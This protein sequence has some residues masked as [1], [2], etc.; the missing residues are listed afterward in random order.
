MDVLLERLQETLS[1]LELNW[2]V[3]FVDDGSRDGTLDRLRDLSL[4]RPEV[5]YVALTRNFGHEAATTAGLSH[6]RGD[7]V[8]LMDADLQD[9]PEVIPDMVRL[10]RQ[11]YHL[12]YA[13]RDAREGEG[14]LK[15]WTSRLF[16]RIMARITSF[17]L[18]ADV[19][20]FRL[21]SRPAVEALLRMPERNRFVRGMVAWSGFRS[22]AV[23]FRRAPRHSGV[24]KYSMWRLIVLAL[25]A[26]TSFSA[27]P[28]RLVSVAGLV[29]TGLSLLGAATVVVQKLFFG[30]PIPGYAFLVTGVFFL[31][32]VQILMLGVIGEYVGR[33]FVDTQRRPI[34]VVAER[35]GFEETWNEADG[36][37]ITPRGG[38]DV[39]RETESR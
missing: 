28:L 10:W 5:R 38:Y 19:G 32:G 35:G 33:I 20:D 17:D 21:M 29:V 8:V 11:G 9:P 26:M 7:A 1:A 23:T 34:Y 37:G 36:A 4:S 3:L 2:E 18:P 30:I 25:D 24:T 13:R 15:R 39:G 6:V 12:V 14:V 27:V 31:G 22:A 16:Y